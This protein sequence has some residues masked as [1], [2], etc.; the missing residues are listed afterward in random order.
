MG[1][2][3]FHEPK[4]PRIASLISFKSLSEAKQKGA[5]IRYNFKNAVEQRKRDRALVYLRSVVEARN[6]LKATLKRR[7]LKKETRKK[8]RRLFKYYDTLAKRLSELYQKAF[9]KKK[10]RR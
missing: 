4:H 5:V 8:F 3:L 6:R 9:K 10:K 7:D 2:G 1:Y